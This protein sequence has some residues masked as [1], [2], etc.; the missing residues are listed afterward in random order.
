MNPCSKP[1]I[2]AAPALVRGPAHR[3]APGR[4]RS[5]DPTHDS[6]WLSGSTRHEETVQVV[7]RRSIGIATAGGDAEVGGVALEL[8]RLANNDPATL[9]HALVVCSSLARHD[10]TN[11]RLNRAIRL[12]ERVIAFLAVPAQA[13]S[14]A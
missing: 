4:T 3:P 7:V 2:V 11:E 12:L 5:S 6:S 8:L 13:I 9:E 10:P 14:A 1:G